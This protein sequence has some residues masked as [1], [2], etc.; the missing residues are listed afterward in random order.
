MKEIHMIQQIKNSEGYEE[1]NTPK[2]NKTDLT[3][4]SFEKQ[5]RACGSDISPHSYEE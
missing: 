3:D 2:S 4:S 5:L 1:I